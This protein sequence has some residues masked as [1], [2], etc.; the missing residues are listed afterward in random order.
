MPDAGPVLLARVGVRLGNLR[1]G[2]ELESPSGRVAVVGPS[3]A[4]KST[5]LRILAGLEPRAE[6]TVQVRGETWMD[7]AAGVWLEP[8]RRRVG[9]VPQDTLLFPHLSVRENLAYGMAGLG[10]E[11]DGSGEG[12]LRA[13]AELVE[14][15]HLLDRRPAV[16]SGGERQRVAVARALLSDPVLLLLDEPFSALDRPLRD[17]LARRLKDYV[18]AERL[19]VVLVSHDEEDAHALGCREF[20]LVEG[21]LRD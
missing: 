7:R 3:G 20:H 16:L 10:P 11:R 4:G 5:L 14:A 12:R 19:P 1:L 17:D 13:L 2:V 6:G 18:A 8:W 15:S 21:R 9:W